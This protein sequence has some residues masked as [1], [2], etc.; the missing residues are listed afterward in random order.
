MKVNFSIN[1]DGKTIE[2][3]VEVF[4][5]TSDREID[6]LLTTWVMEITDAEWEEVEE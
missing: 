6:D 1:V 2:E 5:N 4:D 3:V